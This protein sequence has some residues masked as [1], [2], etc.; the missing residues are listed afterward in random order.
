VASTP[1]TLSLNSQSTGS[2]T[3]IQGKLTTKNGEAVPG[4]TIA[5]TARGKTLIRVQT[6]ATGT[7]NTQVPLSGINRS[8]DSQVKLTAI[9]TAQGTNLEP[10]QASVTIKLND[11]ET[12]KQIAPGTQGGTSSPPPQGDFPL[13]ILALSGLLVLSFVGGGVWYR[14]LSPPSQTTESS[15][16]TN[17][18]VQNASE[19]SQK[20]RFE[21]A[22]QLL[23]N[24]DYTEAIQ[25]AYSKFRRTVDEQ[26]PTRTNREFY[27]TFRIEKNLDPETDTLL[28][29]LTEAFEH[30]VYA[31]GSPSENE[32]QNAIK[33]AE[34]LLDHLPTSDSIS[35]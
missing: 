17:S 21:E 18:P 16:Q 29:S 11:S 7:F 20:P 6:S 19:L 12:S 34:T 31:P 4:Q 3:Q 25:N 15:E 13:W 26:K 22:E 5:L 14:R 1:T 30:A 23:E 32:A 10:S 28:Q 9:Y 24:G 8:T 33:A 2:Q 35:S 27:E